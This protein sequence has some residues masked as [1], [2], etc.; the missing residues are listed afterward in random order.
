MMA[1]CCLMDQVADVETQAVGGTVLVEGAGTPCR[2]ASST[3]RVRCP[4]SETPFE[5]RV[6][7]GTARRRTTMCLEQ[8]C[9]QRAR[10]SA[11]YN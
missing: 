3:R 9:A 10:G 4:P 11:A 1:G 2:G 6:V 8:I 7:A 5:E